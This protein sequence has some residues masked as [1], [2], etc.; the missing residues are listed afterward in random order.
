MSGTLV[1]RATAVGAD[2]R[3]AK[4]TELVNESQQGKARSRPARMRVKCCGWPEPS[5]P[6]PSTR[7]AV[8]S[9]RPQRRTV[10]CRP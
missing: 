10:R 3:L 5:S 1:V 6:P 7:S 2:T 8:R 4:I 9:P